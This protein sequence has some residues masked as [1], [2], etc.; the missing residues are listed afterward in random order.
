[1]EEWLQSVGINSDANTNYPKTFCKYIPPEYTDSYLSS[2]THWFSHPLRFEDKYDGKWYDFPISDE[3]SDQE[4]D[5]LEYFHDNTLNDELNP[6][7]STLKICS[8]TTNPLCIDMWNNYADDSKGICVEYDIDWVNTWDYYADP[9]YKRLRPMIYLDEKADLSDILIAREKALETNPNY[10][11]STL[12]C[13]GIYMSLL[14]DAKYRHE[15]EWR[16]FYFEDSIGNPM[17]YG[18]V[19]DGVFPPS[20]ARIDRDDWPNTPDERIEMILDVIANP[21]NN[22]ELESKEDD[23]C[24]YGVLYPCPTIPKNIYIGENTPDILKDKVK[25]KAKRHDFYVYQVVR[26]NNDLKAELIYEPDV[27]EWWLTHKAIPL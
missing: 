9:L 22:D 16:A 3:R 6:L 18:Y 10:R 21:Q 20:F 24:P 8:F 13:L 19:K 2:F 25:D 26:E 11:L 12:K 17:F 14:K 7:R 5:I 27:P 15:D 1:M 4:R 23:K